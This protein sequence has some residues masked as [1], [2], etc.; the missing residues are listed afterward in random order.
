VRIVVD[1][2]TY[3]YSNMGDVAML[4][5]AVIRLKKLWPTASIEIFSEAPNTLPIYC[6]EAKPLPCY[7]RH[8]WFSDHVL[9]GRYH[10]FL[11]KTVSLSLTAL[12]RAFGR[13]WPAFVGTLIHLRFGLR[14]TQN[15]DT[16]D[17]LNSMASADLIVVTGAGGFSDHSP[18]WNM[19]VLNTLEMAI[20]H[21]TPVAMFG[22]GLGPLEDHETL[23]RARVILPWVSLISLR[24]SRASLPLLQSLGVATNRILTTGDEAVELA[25][26]ARSNKLGNG[27]G[28]N[29]RVASHAGVESSA[30]EK[31]RPILQAFA[32]KYQ[33]PIVPVPISFSASN[34]DH[35]TIKQL[36]AGYDDRSD[37][38]GINLNT[39]LK[40]IKQAGHC[41]IVLAGAYHAA[42]FALAQ[43]IPVV[44]LA[45]SAYYVDKFIGL[46]DQF[47]SGC[48]VVR[49]NDGDLKEELSAALD[50]AWQMAE[51][52]HLSLLKA[53]QRQIELGWAAYQRVKKL[54]CSHTS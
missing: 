41:R 36:L 8:L 52:V 3:D 28:V 19:T 5:V 38:G 24:E 45:K 23:A 32:G 50:K 44:C 14:G 15:D 13:R 16:R 26:K 54:I 22:Q 42:V 18:A 33:A 20:Q 37:G 21:K 43:G 31:I 11:P 34:Q 4:Q 47:G 48:E 49:L 6:P 39:P 9:L 2:G 1:T 40:V 10:R 53:S 25:Y 30:I 46:S 29:L 12:K 51:E 27:I 35:E 7:G 17:F